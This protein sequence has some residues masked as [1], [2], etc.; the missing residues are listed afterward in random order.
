MISLVC[1]TKGEPHAP[2]FLNEMHNFCVKHNAEFIVG[3]DGDKG[4]QMAQLFGDVAVQVHSEGYLESVIDEVLAKANFEWVLRLDDDETMSPA[5]EEWIVGRSWKDASET[6]YSFPTA[7]LW[8][9]RNH[10]I[11]VPPFVGDFHPRFTRK[12]SS[13][14]VERVPHAGNIHGLGTIVPVLHLHHKFLVKD[15][16]KRY[17]IA[18]RYESLRE[19]AGFGLHRPFTLPELSHHSFTVVPVGTGVVPE[20]MTE[21]IGT[22]MQVPISRTATMKAFLVM[23]P[24]SSGTRMLTGSLIMAGAY[25]QDTH[26]QD[27]D[28]LRFEDRDDIIVLRRSIPHANKKPDLAGIYTLMSNAGYKVFPIYISRLDEYTAKSQILNGHSEVPSEA[29][30]KIREAEAHAIES[31][32]RIGV[33]LIRLSY[34]AFIED[35]QIREDFFYLLGMPYPE[36]MKYY[37]ANQ[38]YREGA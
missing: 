16:E 5:M 28:D 32:L 2:Y 6:I 25:G 18:C 12:D 3:G 24:E 20:D 8:G 33:Q 30:Q 34:E 31:F 14:G 29:Y 23:G 11:T 27:L 35:R 22:G 15:Y 36:D 37:D 17:E 38:K 21:L 4:Y 7:W 26:Q 19:G 10:F 1:V 9:D 13:M